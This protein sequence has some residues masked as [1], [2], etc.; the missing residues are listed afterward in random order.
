MVTMSAFEYG[1]SCTAFDPTEPTAITDESRPEEMNVD[2]PDS[3]VRQWSER[4]LF[5]MFAEAKEEAG[6]ALA[7]DKAEEAAKLKALLQRRPE[8]FW[9]EEDIWGLFSRKQDV[10]TLQDILRT[11]S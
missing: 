10:A 3:G 1:P 5:D 7:K 2:P 6:Q 9:S 11:V 8:A 4:A